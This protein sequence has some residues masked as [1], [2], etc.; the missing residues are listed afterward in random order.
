MGRARPSTGTNTVASPRSCWNSS[1]AYTP[2]WG[3]P[4]A[5]PGRGRWRAV[6]RARPATRPGR[7][8]D[9]PPPRWRPPR[10]RARCDAR[11]RAASRRLQQVAQ[12][13]DRGPGL[14]QLGLQP[15]QVG[16]DQRVAGG[17]VRCGQHRLDLGDRHLQIPQAPD[18][19]RG[20]DLPGRVVAV[21]R[22]RVHR[23]RLEQPDLV[24]VA[25]RLDAEMSSAGEIAHG[26]ACCHLAIVN[27]PVTGRSSA[28]GPLTLRPPEHR[29]WSHQ[30]K[31][32][33]TSPKEQTQ[34]RKNNKQTD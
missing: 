21:A 24:V 16:G 13:L 19:L 15:V 27:P 18:D 23:G 2:P 30:P 10:W 17:R 31:R 7:P 1:L 32:T 14:G 20:R 29:G 22:V 34:A 28:R 26:E 25:Q 8:R 11:S 9:R 4:R 12:R 5:G 3:R 33:S 6:R